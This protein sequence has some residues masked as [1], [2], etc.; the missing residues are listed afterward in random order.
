VL[1]QTAVIDI[2]DDGSRSKAYVEPET[3]DIAADP[4]VQYMSADQLKRNVELLEQQMRKAAK[5]L[6]FIEAARLRDE[7]RALQA[8]LE[9]KE[10]P[11]KKA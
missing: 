10:Q 8:L 7:M 1:R 2:H 5:E 6:D 9:E 4:V 3:Y 11:S